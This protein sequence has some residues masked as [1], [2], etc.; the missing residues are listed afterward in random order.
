M[1][2]SCSSSDLLRH[3]DTSSDVLWHPR[4]YPSSSYVHTLMHG[5]YFAFGM[6][7]VPSFDCS[8]IVE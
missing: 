5:E 7:S 1:P 4:Q 3:V 6:L 2:E 8:E